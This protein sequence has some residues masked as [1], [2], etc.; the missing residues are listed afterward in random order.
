VCSRSGL[1]L[2]ICGNGLR[3][4][5]WAD[6]GICRESWHDLISR[7]GRADV[8]RFTAPGQVK[9][10]IGNKYSIT[11]NAIPLFVPFSRSVSWVHTSWC[12]WS[13]FT[14]SRLVW[15]DIVWDGRSFKAWDI[16]FLRILIDRWEDSRWC[17]TEEKGRWQKGQIQN[18]LNGNCLCKQVLPKI[19][20]S[21]YLPNRSRQCDYISG[22]VPYVSKCYKYQKIM[23]PISQSKREEMLR[24]SR[25]GAQ[26]LHLSKAPRKNTRY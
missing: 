25:D 15:G 17:T 5:Q 13:L 23:S 8:I 24:I 1:R 16:F 11:H 26:H 9:K 7:S 18:T 22:D 14:G 19:K 12:N 3:Y 10:Q 2:Q 6:L 4:S 20:G 21:H